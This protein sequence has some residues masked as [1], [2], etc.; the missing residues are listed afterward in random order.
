M[1]GTLCADRRRAIRK[2]VDKSLNLSRSL[3]YSNLSATMERFSLDNMNA[4]DTSLAQLSGLSNY[5]DMTDSSHLQNEKDES[6]MKMIQTLQSEIKLLRSELEKTSGSSSKVILKKERKS[7]PIS[8]DQHS[9]SE[10]WSEPDRDVSQARIGLED[11]IPTKIKFNQHSS[12]SDSD[13]ATQNMKL[14]IKKTDLTEKI[15]NLEKEIV[16]CNLKLKDESIRYENLQKSTAAELDNYRRFNDMLEEEIEQLKN[17]IRELQD[18]NGRVTMSRDEAKI[19][20]R[21]ATVKLETLRTDFEDLEDRHKVEIDNILTNEHDRFENMKKE[22]KEKHNEILKNKE[23]E[24]ENRIKENWINRDLYN[25]KLVELC[26]IKDRLDEA[27]ANLINNSTLQKNL[28]KQIKDS[29]M[30]VMA[31]QKK[32]DESTLQISKAVL[33]RSKALNEKAKLEDDVQLITNNFNQIKIEQASL[34]AQV[35]RL[36]DLNATLQNRVLN[37]EKITYSNKNNGLQS[38]YVSEDMPVESSTDIDSKV[39]VRLE[40]SSPDLGIESGGDARNEKVEL[41][42]SMRNLITDTDAESEYIFLR[43]SF[44]LN[45]I[46]TYNKALNYSCYI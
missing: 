41:S 39:C 23:M 17:V 40:N 15:E 37:E 27:N 32:M 29:E 42:P 19:D 44:N 1:T 9:E 4:T 30:A 7:M 6:Q 35:I 22:L 5:L 20:L 46:L 33:E 16:Q 14:S 13:T 11:I 10:A 45:F 18:Y 31:M 12:T 21:V 25:E 3:T 36:Q 8:L 24:F 38:G 2:A 43:C 34:Q 26:D 28:L